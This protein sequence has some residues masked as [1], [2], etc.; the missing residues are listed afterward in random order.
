MGEDTKKKGTSKRI[1][2]IHTGQKVLEA[3]IIHRGSEDLYSRS[4]PGF[5]SILRSDFKTYVHSLMPCFFLLSGK[6]LKRK[7]RAGK[8]TE[9]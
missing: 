8:M 7:S 5:N 4:F 1:I 6:Y 9:G 2:Y 3:C